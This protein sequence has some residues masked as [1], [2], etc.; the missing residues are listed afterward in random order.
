MYIKYQL[1]FFIQ[2]FLELKIE[3]FLCAFEK[4]SNRDMT[5]VVAWGCPFTNMEKQCL[6]LILCDWKGLNF[7]EL[8]ML[9]CLQ[10]NHRG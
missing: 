10:S 6:Y 4:S 3:S 2:V 9:T 7:L 1:E 5:F 8:Q